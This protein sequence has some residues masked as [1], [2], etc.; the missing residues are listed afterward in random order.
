MTGGPKTSNSSEKAA[1]SQRMLGLLLAMAMFV[2]V[3]DTSLMNV[4]ISSVVRDLEATVSGVQA[5]IALEALVSAAFILIGGKVGD[6]IGRKRAY[7]LGLLGYAIGAS[8]MALAQS[9]TAIIIFWAILGGIGASLLLPAMQSLIHGNFEGAAQKKVYALVGA[10]AAIAAAVGPLLGGFITTYLSWRVG[11]M[12][13]VVIIAVVLSG[14]RLVQDVRYTGPRVIDMVGA[15]L[16]VLGMGGIVLGI[17]VWQEGGEAVG[18]LL[19]LGAVAMAGL[20]YWLVRRK[21]GGK[22]TLLD[23]D[24]FRSKVFRLGITGQMLQQIALGGTMI[25]LPIYLQM[26]LE[27]NAMQAGLSLAPLSLSMF[28]VALLAGKKAGDRRPSSIIR[29]GFVL[30]TVGIAALIPLVPRAEF[31]WGLVIPLVIAGSGLGLL[32]SQLNNY[33]LAP[34]EEERISEAASVNSAAGSFGLSF[35]L[36]FAGAIMLATLSLT[37]TAM[38]QSSNV[39]PPAEQQQVARVLEDDAEVMSNTQLEQLL[40]GQPPEI[41]EEIIRINTDARP[42]ALQFALL[43]PIFAGLIGVFNSFR[44]RRILDLAPKNSGE[45]PQED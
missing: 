44:M 10:A 2:L 5:A 24:L 13:E 16:S 33:T 4:S 25:A 29:W 27:Y 26:V 21:R 1:G 8:A 20:A 23:P 41:Q 42:L 3:V 40:V 9:L 18:A 34:I 39:L 17:L 6:L 19:A 36:A 11:F 14:V 12:L 35:G 30:L 28:A 37:F 32:V 22:P 15:A 45:S 7:V 43:I 38:A 31:G